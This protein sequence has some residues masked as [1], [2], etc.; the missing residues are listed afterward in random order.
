MVEY[1]GP[2]RTRYKVKPDGWFD[3]GTYAIMVDDYSDGHW[4]CGEHNKNCGM[5]LM[6][7][8]KNGKLDEEVCNLCEFEEPEV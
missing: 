8:Y 6:C 7:G 4:I 3:E 5:A 1:H 2:L